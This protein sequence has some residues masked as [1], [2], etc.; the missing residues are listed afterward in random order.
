M[1]RLLIVDDERTTREG[2]RDC[3][4]WHKYGVEV[5]AVAYN[6]QEA[7]KWLLQE[8]VDIVLTDVVM[9]MMDGIELVKQIRQRQIPVKIIFVSGYWDMPYLKSAFQLD[10]IDYILKPVKLTELEKVIQKV[11]SICIEEQNERKVLQELKNKLAAS[12]PLL[13]EQ[14][15]NKL[16]SGRFRDK[17]SIF[18]RAS[19]LEIPFTSNSYYT[20]FTIQLS[21][22]TSEDAREIEKTENMEKQEIEQMLIKETLETFFKDR[23]QIYCLIQDHHIYLILN[24]GKSLPYNEFLSIAQQ[25]QELIDNIIKSKVSIGIGEEVSNIE[26]LNRSWQRSLRALEQGCFFGGNEIVH[27]L[28]QDV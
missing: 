20:V 1:F 4:E 22:P 12:M 2:L 21:T 19:F 5:A 8:T 13:R 7:L 23:Y 9:P 24:N 16:I 10:A 26:H 15:L 6:G 14:F 28:T 25:I 3:V 27:Y 17:E 11:V 18:Q